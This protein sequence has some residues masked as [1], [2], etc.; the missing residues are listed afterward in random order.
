MLTV[1]RVF[2]FVFSGLNIATVY[3][4]DVVENNRLAAPLIMPES[5]ESA[6]ASIARLY[7]YITKLLNKLFAFVDQC[8]MMKKKMIVYF[9]IFINTH[10]YLISVLS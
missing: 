9:N 5:Q 4:I 6:A 10:I 8:D 7:I 3:A 1:W 2:F